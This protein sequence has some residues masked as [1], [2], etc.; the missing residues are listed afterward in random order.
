M[1]DKDLEVNFFQRLQN[2]LALNRQIDQ[3]NDVNE[4]TEDYQANQEYVKA[5]IRA[6][7]ALESSELGITV[8]TIVAQNT[9]MTF[10]TDTHQFSFVAFEA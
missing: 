8:L 2:V 6:S 5:K 9:L 1:V 4:H 10:S 7:F 3:Y